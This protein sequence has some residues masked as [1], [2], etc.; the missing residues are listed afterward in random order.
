MSFQSATGVDRS[1]NCVENA[2]EL[3]TLR[4]LPDFFSSILFVFFAPFS[5]F[6]TLPAFPLCASP[7]AMASTIGRP[8]PSRR[9]LNRTRESLLVFDENARALSYQMSQQR[10][11][12]FIARVCPVNVVRRGRTFPSS[13]KLQVDAL[14]RMCDI[15][16]TIPRFP[17]IMFPSHKFNFDETIKS[18]LLIF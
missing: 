14:M 13:F 2:N 8:V 7:V 12:V 11:P 18:F 1:S 6:L 15:C 5:F 3:H 17:V 10:T 16:Y 9:V 4:T